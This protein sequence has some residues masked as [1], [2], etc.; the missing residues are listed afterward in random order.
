VQAAL[1]LNY[2]TR[3]VG[4][5]SLNNIAA[6]RHQFTTF[7]RRVRGTS[8]LF[9][10]L[11]DVRLASQDRVGVTHPIGSQDILEVTILKQPADF[12]SVVFEPSLQ[13]PMTKTD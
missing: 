13:S 10:S 11:F 3:V 2:G 1:S 7:Q 12:N 5:G 9:L 6:A 8:P 4:G